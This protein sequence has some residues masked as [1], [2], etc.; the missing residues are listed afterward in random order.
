MTLDGMARIVRVE[1][2]DLVTGENKRP[3]SL[4]FGGYELL[5]TGF[6]LKFLRRFEWGVRYS[7]WRV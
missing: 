5:E 4:Q 6:S 3:C 7:E 2:L 1:G